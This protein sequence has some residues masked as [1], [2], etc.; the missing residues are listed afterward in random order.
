MN[1]QDLLHDLATRGVILSSD[2]DHLDVDGPADVLTDE[3]IATLK[4]H[5]SE[6]LELLAPSKTTERPRPGSFARPMPVRGARM[7]SGCLWESCDGS[8]AKRIHS[9]Y[10][11]SKCETWFELLPPEDLGAY[12]GDLAGDLDAG[13]ATEWVM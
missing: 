3:M 10:L 5:K 4:A 11:C 7:P 9:L 2:G 13:D 1:A 8:L 6:L 12:V